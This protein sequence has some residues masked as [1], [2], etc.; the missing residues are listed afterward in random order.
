MGR[1]IGYMLVPF[2]GG[3]INL[4]GPVGKREVPFLTHL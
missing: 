3:A 2:W 4:G 1:S